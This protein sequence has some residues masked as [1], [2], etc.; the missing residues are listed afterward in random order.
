MFD[1]HILDHA[2][3]HLEPANRDHILDPVN[4]GE[5]PVRVD[6]CHIAGAQIAFAVAFNKGVTIAFGAVPITAH[7]LRAAHGEFARL[8]IGGETGR[9]FLVEQD[10][11]RAGHQL[12]D[13]ATFARAFIRI[14]RHHAR[15]F[16][17]A[18]AFYQP[19]PGDFLKLHMHRCRHRRAAGNADFEAGKIGFRQIGIIEHCLKHRRHTGKAGAAIAR[20]RLQ[21]L[22]CFK[23]R[24]HCDRS[25]G[26]DGVVQYRGVGEHMEERQR[27]H[28]HFAARIAKRVDRGDLLRVDAELIVPQH[29]ALGPPGGAAGILQQ[30]QIGVRIERNGGEGRVGRAILPA[31][32][33]LPIGD[34]GDLFALEQFEGDA[35]RPGEHIGKAADHQHF[36]PGCGLHLGCGAI[37]FGHIQRHQHPRA[38]VFD[39]PAQLLN[40]IERREIDDNRPCH[41]RPVIGGG[42]DRDVGQEQ[43]D[44]VA[45]GNPH[46]LKARS[47][48]LRLCADFTIGIGAPEEMQERRVGGLPGGAFKQRWQ[49]DRRKLCVGR[50]RVVIGSVIDSH[51]SDGD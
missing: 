13:G 1:N 26:D 27:P 29:R 24:H 49:A 42:V 19:H 14:G 9:V 23:P 30:C 15:T 35:L 6:L 2:G 48:A 51:D 37:K 45:L 10:H 36:Q 16:G 50:G 4:D 32:D 5:E 22:L 8:A 20:Y 39:L 7:H 31:A 12:P 34:I 43:A 47:K 38:A 25:A 44:P 3:E 41:H 17:E 18:I 33:G 21:H 40:R 11:L 28:K 46:R